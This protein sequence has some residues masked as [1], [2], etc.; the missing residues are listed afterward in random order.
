MPRVPAEL[1]YAPCM[2]PPD[3]DQS[4]ILFVVAGR[5]EKAQ[6]MSRNADTP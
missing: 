2:R 4:R 5:R 3:N 1:I 6:T